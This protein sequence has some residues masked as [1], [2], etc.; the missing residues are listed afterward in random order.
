MGLAEGS[1]DVCL[2]SDLCTSG[3]CTMEGRQAPKETVLV[4]VGGEAQWSVY[5]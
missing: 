1:A 3:P 4:M 2:A 5:P